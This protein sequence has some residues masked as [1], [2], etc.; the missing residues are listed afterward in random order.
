[1]SSHLC[2][3]YL[4]VL[5]LVSSAAWQLDTTFT[6]TLVGSLMALLAN[7]NRGPS[8]WTESVWWVVALINSV[9]R[10]IVRSNIIT[11]I[12]VVGFAIDQHNY[13]YTNFVS[14]CSHLSVNYGSI[15][16]GL[17]RRG[18]CIPR[19]NSSMWQIE[20]ICVKHTLCVWMCVYMAF[21]IMGL[22]HCWSLFN[23]TSC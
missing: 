15:T 12:H 13:M 6:T 5:T 7:Q 21:W 10:V 19:P 4:Q 8:V 11:T 9:I 16:C 17:G 18:T 3:F 23:F 2:V 20:S 22:C 14:P 1:M